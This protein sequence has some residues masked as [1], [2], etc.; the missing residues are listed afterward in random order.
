MPLAYIRCVVTVS[1]RMLSPYAHV[2]VHAPAGHARATLASLH[3]TLASS[4]A[5]P[6]SGEALTSPTFHACAC[7]QRLCLSMYMQYLFWDMDADIC[8][9]ECASLVIVL[10]QSCGRFDLLNKLF[11]ASGQWEKAIAV[12]EEHDR[13]H[14]KTTHYLVRGSSHSLSLYEFQG[15]VQ[16]VRKE[17]TLSQAWNAGDY[18]G[19]TPR[20]STSS[21]SACTRR[22]CR[23]A[24]LCF[25]IC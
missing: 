6:C 20:G 16:R 24:P 8:M 5:L 11:Q 9:D 1:K 13:I 2:R 10:M 18:A 7:V 4:H 23:I 25:S 12:A 22:F 21:L 15:T 14:L 19:V 3:G 17:L